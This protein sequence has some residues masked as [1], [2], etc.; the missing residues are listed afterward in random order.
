MHVEVNRQHLLD[1]A[2][3]CD[4]YVEV[5]NR[6]IK[7]ADVTIKNMLARSWKGDDAQKFAEQWENVDSPDSQT[8]R[9]RDNVQALGGR[10]QACEKEYRKAQEKIFNEASRL[11][12]WLI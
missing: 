9:F 1:V 7:I 2:S 4:A 3:A 11:P 10:L 8:V 5:Q 12:K 6:E